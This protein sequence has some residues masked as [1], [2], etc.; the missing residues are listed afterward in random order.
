MQVSPL[1]QNH[2]LDIFE[3]STDPIYVCS[4]ENAIIE[5]ANKAT[6]QAWGKTDS[7][8]G[9]PILEGL[10]ELNE[11]AFPALLSNVY[12]TGVPYRSE[13]DRADLEIDGV[14][15]TF[16]FKFTYQPLR[17]NEGTIWGV[18][19]NA[20]DVTELVNAR[21]AVEDSQ[22]DLRSMIVQAPVA[23]CILKGKSFIVDIANDKMIE[24]WGTTNAIVGKPFFDGLPEAKG[25]GFEQLLEG[26]LNTGESFSALER[27]TDLPRN[28]KV[29]KVFVNFVYEALK[30]NSDSITAV[31]AV[32]TDVTQQV[33]ARKKVEESER[34]MRQ[35]ADSMPQMVWV[36]DAQG[37]HK[38]Y[39]KRWYDFTCT[40]YEQVKG[41]GWSDLFHPDDRP[42]AWEKW[43]HSLATGDTYEVEYRLKN[44]NT[45]E[46]I[47]VLGRAVPIYNEE[48]QIIRW[49][50]TCTDINEHKQLQQ[51]KDDFIGIASHELKTPLT[52]LK[53]SLQLIGRLIKRDPESQMLTRFV[54]Q[55]NK[56]IGK[57]GYLVEDL[58]NFTR[59]NEGQLGLNKEDVVLSQLLNDCCQH[60]RADNYKITTTGDLSLSAC[61][62]AHRIDQVIVNLV[63]NAVKYAAESKEITLTIEKLPGYAKVSVTDY[64]PGIPQEKLEHLFNRYYRVDSSGSQVSGLGLGLFICKEIVSRHKGEI[65]VNSRLGEGS[66]FW[67]TLPLEDS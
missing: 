25:Q 67:F 27:P 21:K 32:A 63:N 19:C 5:Y 23:I 44:G 36:T 48:H 13:H 35:I 56:S 29:E 8:I 50:G 51:H 7:V 1:F 46:Y 38:Y 16:Y 33:L 43:N 18:L 59:L 12:R 17:N 14:L 4:G 11:Q 28:G 53:A 66:T 45:G 22:K 34:E 47:W 65:G 41:E 62:D 26:V 40:N 2:L 52:A 30:D 6:L 49:F 55:S 31:M 58:L 60:I 10:P 54:D 3:A 42:D 15:K 57:L 37:Y 9:K 64:G 61:I 39:N 20:T 24:L